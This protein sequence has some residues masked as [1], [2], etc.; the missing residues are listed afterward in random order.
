L[1]GVIYAA[2]HGTPEMATQGCGFGVVRLARGVTNVQVSGLGGATRT[3]ISDG[4][5]PSVLMRT[6]L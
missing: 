1:A 4:E 2:G 3:V 6:R 5:S